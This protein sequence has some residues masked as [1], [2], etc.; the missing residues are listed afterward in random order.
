MTD[1]PHEHEQDTDLQTFK[2]IVRDEIDRTVLYGAYKD[3]C[4]FNRIN[5]VSA[6]RLYSSVWETFR[7]STL[8]RRDRRV[9]Q[10]LQLIKED[11]EST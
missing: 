5:P 3:W 1:C 7:V 8:K 2:D 6:H 10:G 11:A 4:V 9:L